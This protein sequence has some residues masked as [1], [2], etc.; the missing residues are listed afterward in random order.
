MV[1]QDRLEVVGELPN[2]PRSVGAPA[3]RGGLHA[4]VDH[5]RR[6][7]ALRLGAAL[8]EPVLQVRGLPEQ[9]VGQRLADLVP[10][11]AL[12]ELEHVDAHD[13]HGDAGAEQDD[14][15]DLGL[16]ADAIGTRCDDALI[17]H[18]L[19]GRWYIRE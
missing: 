3:F 8:L 18:G 2:R 9:G 10:Q 17:A 4:F 19:Q 7:P 15:E 16:K 13:Q 14:E 6:G 12:V 11:N 5:V 1:P